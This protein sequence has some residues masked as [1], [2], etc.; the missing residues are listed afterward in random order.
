MIKLSPSILAADF[1]ILG[2][3]IDEL[4][5]LGEAAPY[6]HIDV[7]DGIFV[8]SISFGM[9]VIESLRKAT[10]KVFDVHLMIMDPERYIEEFRACGANII[11]F[12]LEACDA[13]SALI[14]TLHSMGLK[15][16]ITI[17]PETPAELLYPF[18]HEVDMVLIMCVSPG[19]GGQEFLPES[20][21]RIRKLRKYLDSNGLH[22]DIQV[23]GGIYHENV[24]EVLDAGAN[25]IVTGSAVFGGE[26][27]E[28]VRKFSEI[29]AEYG[30]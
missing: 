25:I 28:N 10:E 18:L 21:Y 24:R 22:A 11:T 16:G 20:L 12:H 9:P 13:P 8:P 14:D 29:F 17:K 23:D 2:Q 26:I 4:N 3:Q 15:A 30:K 1:T 7:M 5:E 27:G 6:L 19:F